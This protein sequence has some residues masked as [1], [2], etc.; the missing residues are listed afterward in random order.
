[1]SVN[2]V[3]ALEQSVGK[4]SSIDRPFGVTTGRLCTWP[5]THGFVPVSKWQKG[6]SQA[7][8][9]FEGTTRSRPLPSRLNERQLI[10]IGR[11]KA[12][13]PLSTRLRRPVSPTQIQRK[14]P[15]L[16]RELS[17]SLLMQLEL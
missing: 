3:N 17:A 1:M 9:R 7:C 15:R 14:N 13:R 2:C 10:A 6:A 4:L 12:D 11:P 16:A 5:L 8:S